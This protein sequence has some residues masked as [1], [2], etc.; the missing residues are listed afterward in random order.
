MKKLLVLVGII[1]L[2]IVSITLTSCDSYRL[3]EIEKAVSRDYQKRCRNIVISAKTQ[4]IKVSKNHYKGTVKSI[5]QVGPRYYS[6]ETIVEV[7][8]D[9]RSTFIS[10]PYMR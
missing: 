6:K 8:T 1:A 10:Y 2:L 3:P 7:F 5:E 4:L 9:N